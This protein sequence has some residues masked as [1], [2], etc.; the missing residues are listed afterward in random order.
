MKKFCALALLLAMCVV[1][2]ACSCVADTSDTTAP[3]CDELTIRKLM[4]QNLDCYFIYYVEPL[5]VTTQQNSDGYLGTD[6]SYMKTYSELEN[7]VKT[8]YVKNTADKLLCYPTKE[9]PLYK[10]VDNLIFA[11]PD[12]AEFKKYN[13][14]WEDSYTIKIDSCTD[15]QC[16][17]TLN[18]TDLDSKPYTTQGVAQVQDGKWLLAD[19]IH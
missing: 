14:I 7:L 6:G 2:C 15:T 5:S 8:T 11:K 3:A 13:I 10:G 19:I 18:T 9:T 16:K 17:F 12:V 1:M 4:E